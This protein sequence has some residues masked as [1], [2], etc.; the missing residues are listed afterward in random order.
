MI[1][2][3]NGSKWYME[4]AVFGTLTVKGAAILGSYDSNWG[5]VFGTLS[6][7]NRCS[8]L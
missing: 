7:S 8:I 2:V 5:T 4:V 6:D 1:S 3:R